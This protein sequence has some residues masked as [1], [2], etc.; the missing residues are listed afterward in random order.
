[1]LSSH[2]CIEFVAALCVCQTQ[3]WKLNKD[4]QYIFE[5]TF[6]DLSQ[7]HY[8]RIFLLLFDMKVYKVWK[9]FSSGVRITMTI[10]F[11]QVLKTDSVCLCISDG[12]LLPVLAHYLGAKQVEYFVLFF[13]SLYFSLAFFSHVVNF[14]LIIKLFAVPLQGQVRTRLT[15]S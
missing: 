8:M 14:Q 11:L 7:G 4:V 9:M 1:M 10:C 12:S 3:Y 2:F 13:R 15:L 6:S 5:Q